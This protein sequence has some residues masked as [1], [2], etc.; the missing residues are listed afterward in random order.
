[1]FNKI[2]IVT[3]FAIILSVGTFAQ[4]TEVP[5][6]KVSGFFFSGDQTMLQHGVNFFVLQKKQEF[7]K[8]FGKG[9]ADTPNFAKEWMLVMVMP[10]TKKDVQL[11]YNSISMKAGTFVEV[12]C[13]LNKLR[14][15]M[16]T[17]KANPI[18]VCI[19]PKYESVKTV[20]FYEERKK[21][22]LSLVSS[23]EVKQRR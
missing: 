23:V 21:N 14:G 10:A 20:N 17:Y 2:A 12:Y 11:E 15:K 19:I 4:P 22:E 16:L 9:G 18:A 13:D 5:M 6:K 7:E 1:M 3:I 8:L